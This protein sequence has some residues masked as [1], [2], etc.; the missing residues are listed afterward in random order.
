MGQLA[1]S[2]VMDPG[3]GRLFDGTREYLVGQFA[4]LRA[5][6]RSGDWD[7]A[8]MAAGLSESPLAAKVGVFDFGLSKLRDRVN[9]SG[10]TAAAIKLLGPVVDV[11]DAILRSMGI[12]PGAG[13]V[14]EV[15]DALKG[16]VSLGVAAAEATKGEEGH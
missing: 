7:E 15:K 9:L 10:W 6:I 13:Q 12:L 14:S 5:A 4:G 1:A 2:E 8:L 11:A 3:L 16:A